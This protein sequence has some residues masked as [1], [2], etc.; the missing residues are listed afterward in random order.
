MALKKLEGVVNETMDWLDDSQKASKEE[1][2]K[3]KAEL[4]RIA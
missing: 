1:Y 2:E 3:K 4:E